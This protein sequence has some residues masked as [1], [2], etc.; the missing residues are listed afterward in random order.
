ML[1][2]RTMRTCARGAA[3]RKG[4]CTSVYGYSDLTQGNMDRSLRAPYRLANDAPKFIK[5]HPEEPDHGPAMAVLE[6]GTRIISYDLKGADSVIGFYADA[7]CIYESEEDA[8]ISHYGHMMLPKSNLLSSEFNNFK[9]MQ[10]AAANQWDG[11]IAKKYVFVKVECRR[12]QVL[13]LMRRMCETFFLPRFA[14]GEMGKTHEFVE[15]I[16]ATLHHEP[17]PF[18]QHMMTSKGFDGTCYAK[19]PTCPKYNVNKINSDR[20]VNWWADH[21]HPNSIQIVGINVSQEELQFAYE[22][23]EWSVSN[24]AGHTHTT[25]QKRIGANGIGKKHGYI[26]GEFREYYRAS[27]K[28]PKLKFYDDVHIGYGRL[29]YG[30]SNLKEFATMLVASSAIQMNATPFYDHFDGTGLVGGIVRCRP[31]E[32]ADVSR[33]LASRIDGVGSLAGY[34]LIA[35]KKRAMVDFSAATDKREGLCDFLALHSTEG[36]VRDPADVLQAI[37]DVSAADLATASDYMHSADPTYVV[38]G[39]CNSVPSLGAMKK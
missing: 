38:Y 30:R 39:A 6:E 8:G 36:D 17:L 28:F 9:T 18:V 29:G 3:Q 37:H 12:D 33:L 5:R 1:A 15:N 13:Q 19:S 21:F 35:A 20:L 27:E 2:Q 7:G 34:D 23:S 10:H 26:G 4:Y 22:H 25:P 14:V 16:A 11:Q 32:A 24:T 31:D